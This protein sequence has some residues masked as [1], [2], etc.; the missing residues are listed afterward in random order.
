LAEPL[1]TGA[2]CRDFTGEVNTYFE[3]FVCSVEIHT[4]RSKIII[5]AH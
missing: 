2:H 1:G 4:L 3:T 5:F